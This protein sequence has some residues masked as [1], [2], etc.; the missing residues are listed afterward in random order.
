VS[1]RWQEAQIRA[2]VVAVVEQPVARQTGRPSSGW[3]GEGKSTLLAGS[4]PASVTKSGV[5]RAATSVACRSVTASA[6]T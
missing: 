1:R 4:H 5:T 3:A 6:N 2:R